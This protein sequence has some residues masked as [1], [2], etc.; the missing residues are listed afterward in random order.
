MRRRYDAAKH[1]RRSV[2]L[3]GYDYRRAGAYF[4]TICLRHRRQM[5]GEVVDG[6]VYLNDV[7]LSVE[8]FWDVLPTAFPTVSLDYCVFMPDHMHGILVIEERKAVSSPG[9]TAD[10][11]SDT[12][13]SPR[14][15]D[16]VKTFKGWASYY[17]HAGGAPDFAWQRNY[18]EHIIRHEGQL[19][20]VRRYIVNNPEK[21][22]LETDGDE[23]WEYIMRTYGGV[24]SP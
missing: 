8:Y 6:V 23:M 1:H 14:L 4:V 10:G 24:V 20:A 18:Y 7:G 5:L 9:D 19:R 21:W 11:L 2:R 13:R 3:R 16:I 15:G 22:T 17:I 12:R